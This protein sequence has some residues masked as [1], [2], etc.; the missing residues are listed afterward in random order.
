[1]DPWVGPGWP[2]G[3]MGGSWLARVDPGVD[4]GMW[5]QGGCPYA[6]PGC[7][8]SRALL[9]I[10]QS[11]WVHHG[12]T[13]HHRTASVPCTALVTPRPRLAKNDVGDI[14]CLRT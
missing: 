7:L 11:P 5:D 4:H 2:G 9:P 8:G 6:C 3:S 1:M 13:R 10:R 14:C 12:R